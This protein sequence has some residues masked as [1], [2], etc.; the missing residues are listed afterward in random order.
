MGNI[1]IYYKTSFDV[2]LERK[3]GWQTPFNLRVF[4]THPKTGQLA[5]FDGE[6]YDGCTLEEDGRLRIHF[7]DFSRRFHQD[8][9]YLRIQIEDMK[10]DGQF[11]DGV[12]NKFGS[13]KIINGYDESGEGTEEAY[14]QISVAGE[15]RGPFICK[16]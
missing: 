9:G 10:S 6:N 16:I 8:F 13:V 5:K 4:T 14:L 3:N 1:N 15:A 12:L 11:P 2:L 7:F